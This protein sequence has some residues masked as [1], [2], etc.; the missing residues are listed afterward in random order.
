MKLRIGDQVVVTTGKD[1]GKKGLIKKLDLRK[2][3]ALVEGVNQIVK[4][5]KPLMGRAGERIIKDKPID[6]SKVAILNR[7]GEPDR[8]GYTVMKNGEKMRVFRK[9]GELVDES[10]SKTT[11]K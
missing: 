9:S 6:V 5:R 2:K 7:A 4:H 10:N 3:L 8:V 1:K 11:K